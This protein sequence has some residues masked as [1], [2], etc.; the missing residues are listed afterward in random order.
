MLNF[1]LVEKGLLITLCMGYFSY[2]P[3]DMKDSQHLESKGLLLLWFLDFGPK[4]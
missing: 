2:F 1:R 3:S 4:K